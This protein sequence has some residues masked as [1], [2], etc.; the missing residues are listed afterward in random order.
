MSSNQTHHRERI[1][2][3]FFLLC[4]C[5]A[6]LMGR[7]VYLMLY[8]SEHYSQMAEDLHE[9]ERTIKAARGRIL[10]AR[11]TVIATNRTVCTVSVI[12]NQVRDREEVI[13]TLC[14][15]LSMEEA[16]VRKK[17]EK[18]SSREIIRTNV[19]KEI[20][21]RIRGYHLAGVKVDDDY[22]RYYP[23]DS[24]ASR[25]LGFTG[26]DN[27][28]I[29]GLEV[30]YESYLK[31]MNGKILTMTDAAGV[32]IGNTFED[33][34]EPVPGN[35]LQIS[36]DVNIQQYVEQAALETMER[37]GAKR[38]SVIVMN[39]KNGE[40]MAMANVPEFNL[41]DP[42][43]LNVEEPAGTTA[44]Q[45]QELL[46]QM[47]RNPSINDTYEP[48]STF[49][50]IT[51]AAGL[52]AG[53]VGLEDRFSCPGF[54][55]VEDRKIRCHKVGG[56]GAETFLQ[57]TMNSCNPVFIDVG[58]RLGIDAYYRYFEQFGLKEK[59]GIDLPGEAG[60]IMH[61]KENMG[62]VELATV[63][64]GQ[65][66]Q[67]T[68]IQLITTAASI[69]NGGYR[70]IPH[71]GV[72]V[73]N[74]DKT[75]VHRFSYPVKKRIVS[76]ETSATMRY[77]LEQVV[78]EGGGKKAALPGYRIGGKTATSE[79]LP[80][81]LKRYIS[82]FLGF[83]PADDPQVIALITIDEPQGVYYGG[84]IAAPVIADIFKNILPYLG[85]E[86]SAE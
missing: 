44:S 9:R 22:K 35:D 62:L 55:I 49:K 26:G 71:F 11:G 68:P 23:Y 57:G 2:V 36:L 7:L 48:G 76:E 17:V 75:A 1:A 14:R 58:Q 85:I 37:K 64:F 67:I 41:N 65:S 56:H 78:A 4:I 27:Q 12:Y 13:E 46:N 69:V 84:T 66:F 82:S 86:Q 25:V 80:R 74:A 61:K 70:I 81:S 8:R 5:V 60:T 6:G 32:E 28:G 73:M 83:A 63:S 21:D 33:R 34:I 54:R 15:E 30:K 18:R 77:I 38:V 20:G 24:L 43:T 51:A 19:D 72:K 45:R 47:W 52:E 31:G 29:V 50:I 40:I 10:D 59:T 79:K 53:V 16:A 3:L 39:P 42:F